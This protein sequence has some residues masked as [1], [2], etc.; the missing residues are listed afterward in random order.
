[1]SYTVTCGDVLEVWDYAEGEDGRDYLVYSSNRIAARALFRALVMANTHLVASV[2]HLVTVP[3]FVDLRPYRDPVAERPFP[4]VP[5][6]LGAKPCL[7]RVSRARRAQHH[8]HQ[9]RSRRKRRS[10]LHSLR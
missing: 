2:R 8:D 7:L 4:P 1:M 5:K 3:S 10:F 6:R 9:D